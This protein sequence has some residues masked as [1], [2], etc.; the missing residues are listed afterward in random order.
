MTQMGKP[1][2][3]GEIELTLLGP[4]YGESI[5]LHVGGGVW[6][7]VDSCVDTDG[8]PRALRYLESIGVDPAE[9]VVLIVATHWHDDH[10]RGIANLAEICHQATFCCASVFCQKEFL[11]AAH[12]LEGHH[13]SVAGSGLRELHNVIS[14][15]VQVASK[16]VLA[17][18]NRRIFVQG[19]CEI[20]S[21]SPN[22]STFQAFL[23]SIGSL[24]PG[25][26]QGK[27]R[28]PDLSPNEVAVALWVKIEDLA[29]LL[30]S[31][32]EKQGWIQILQNGARPSG[33]ASAFK[34]PHHGSENAHEPSVWERM[35]DSNPVAILTPWHR[36]GSNLPRQQDV[37]RILSCTTNAY[38]TARIG[39][40]TRAPVSRSNMVKR[41]IRESGVKL[42]RLAMSTGAV[43]LRHLLGSR[44]GWKVETFEPACHLKEFAEQ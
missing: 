25:E 5:V 7:L 24:V 43:R 26:G 3:K 44:T 28:I 1:P 29:V 18:A 35:L 27:R 21:L 31:D 23:R 37:R 19:S 39:S 8:T 17:L 10:I 2:R 12:A 22:D 20:W 34:V 4:G 30:G 14:R 16:P 41:T 11:A 13:F 42:R 32:L 15:L 6:V 36:G 38:T 33:R 9:A 40:S